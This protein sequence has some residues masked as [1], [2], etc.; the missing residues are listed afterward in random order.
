MVSGA[1][2]RVASVEQLGLALSVDYQNLTAEPAPGENHG[3]VFTRQ[4]VVE[5]I[6]DLVDYRPDRDLT[7]LRLVEPACGAGAFLGVIAQRISDSCRKFDRPLTDAAD[8]VRAFDILASNVATSTLRVVEVLVAD[9][10]SEQEAT[11]VASQW[12]QRGD[13][14]L[15]LDT[16]RAADVVVGNPPYVRLEN[17]PADRM[18]LY[19]S[20]WPA[21][22]G[23]ADIYVGFFEAGLR[24]LEPGGVLGFICADRWMRNQYGAALRRVVADEFTMDVCMTL[25]DVDAFEASVSAYP[26]VTVMRRGEPGPTVVVEAAAEFDAELAGEFATWVRDGAGC[27]LSRTSMEATRLPHWF[28]GG[29]SWPSGSPARLA[30]LEDLSE[31]FVALGDPSSGVR[32]GIGVA[33]GADAVFLTRDQTIVEADRL[34]PLAMARDTASGTLSWSGCHLVNPWDERGELVD[35][36]RFPMLRQYFEDSRQVLVARHVGKRQPHRWYRTIDKVEPGLAERPKLLFPDMKL[37]SHPVLDAGGFYPHHNLYFLTSDV[38]DLEVLGGLLLSRIAES[39]IEA[40]AVK[41]RGKTLR[42]Q[43]QYLRRIRVPI[44]S[45]ISAEH[46]DALRQAFRTRDVDAATNVALELYG[47]SHWPD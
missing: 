6:L 12:V 37:R 36:Q 44:V 31:R 15:L 11:E 35:L 7:F 8:A 21:M 30:A 45:S 40:Y 46:G 24:S 38:W 3:E 26:A 39:F 27:S 2:S 43:A 10:W 22:S 23:R 9:G 5:M 16:Q 33:T 32:I 34:L 4:W 20:L 47:L 17:V 14:L 18:R 25:H 19:R 13:Y 28:A 1:S 29:D 42:F 41:M